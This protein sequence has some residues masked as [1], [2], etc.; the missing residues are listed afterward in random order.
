L[1]YVEKGRGIKWQCES[2]TPVDDTCTDAF[3]GRISL[4]FETCGVWI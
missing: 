2:V 4:G 1:Y 3:R